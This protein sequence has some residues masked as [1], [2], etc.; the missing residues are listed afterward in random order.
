M[1]EREMKMSKLDLD[2]IRQRAEAAT[3]GPWYGFSS[4]WCVYNTPNSDGELIADVYEY[5][6]YP[7][8]A[9]TQFIAHA[10]EDIPAMLDEIERLRAL[11]QTYQE[12]Q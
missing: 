7:P 12:E 9:N 5:G 4:S 2:A 3:P 6:G 8:D 10:R 1:V 11:L